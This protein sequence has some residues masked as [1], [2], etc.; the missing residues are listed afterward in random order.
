MDMLNQ[1]EPKGG[2]AWRIPALEELSSLLV[3]VRNMDG[4][5]IDPLFDSKQK[6]CWSS[7][8]NP[9]GGAYAVFFFP[10]SVLSNNLEAKAFVRAVKSLE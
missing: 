10:G 5:F 2:L 1:A 8:R 9:A 7:T 3:P 4:L 6:W